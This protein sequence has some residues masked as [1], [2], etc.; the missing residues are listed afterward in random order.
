MH[1]LRTLWS[2]EHHTLI[3]SDIHIGKAAHFRKNGVALP[4]TVNDENAWN[5][6][7]L[8][9]HYQPKEL[10]VVGDLIHHDANNEWHSFV[11]F[12]DH[13]PT[14]RRTLVAGN[15]DRKGLL[16][17]R[18]AGFQVHEH[19][20]FAGIQLLH[21]PPE[22]PQGL[23]CIAGHLHPAVRLNGKARQSLRVP[24]FWFSQQLALLPAFGAFT[25]T[26]VV[27]PKTEDHVFAIAGQRVVAVSK[28]G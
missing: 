6:S 25:G 27:R 26:S 15:H 28:V 16:H 18:N 3:C 17:A 4:S 8:L 24:C 13:W 7:L 1:P 14:M 2:L 10:I 21:Q 23:P 9:H 12:L 11:D 20:V 19:G 22:A 5:L